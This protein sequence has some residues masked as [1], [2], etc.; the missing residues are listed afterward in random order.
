MVVNVKRKLVGAQLWKTH[1]G[2]GYRLWWAWFRVVLAILG[3]NMV[4]E[5]R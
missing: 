5:R 3:T 2:G 4:E 1:G